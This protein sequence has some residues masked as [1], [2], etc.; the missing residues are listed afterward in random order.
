M[1]RKKEE[2]NNRSNFFLSPF[3]KKMQTRAKVSAITNIQEKS[4]TKYIKE[5]NI[6]KK[7]K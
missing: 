3:K 1:R 5:R 4:H 7:N 6:A 2:K